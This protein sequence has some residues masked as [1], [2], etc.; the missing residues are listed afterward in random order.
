M[1]ART[2]ANRHRADVAIPV[3]VLHFQFAEIGQIQ[4]RLHRVQQR[5]RIQ[6]ASDVQHPSAEGDQAAIGRLRPVRRRAFFVIGQDLLRSRAVP[7]HRMI[8]VPAAQH[9]RPQPERLADDA[10]VRR[11]RDRIERASVPRGMRGHQQRPFGAEGIHQRI[12]N[13]VRAAVHG[14]QAAQGRM[15]HHNRTRLQPQPCQPVFNFALS[16]HHSCPG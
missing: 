7:R 1:P 6:V 11:D 12:D 15:N 14:S 3:D 16:Q 13:S 8:R 9:A 4:F 2:P 5:H 10:H